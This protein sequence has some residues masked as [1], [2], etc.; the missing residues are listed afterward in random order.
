MRKFWQTIP[1][2]VRHA[3]GLGTVAHFGGLKSA[4]TY[5]ACAL[6]YEILQWLVER[7]MERVRRGLSERYGVELKQ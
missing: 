4:A 7:D 1:R 6:V 3:G 2:D 5:L